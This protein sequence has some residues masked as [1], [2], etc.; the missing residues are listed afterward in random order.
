MAFCS[1]A[2]SRLTDTDAIPVNIHFLFRKTDDDHHWSGRR[3]LGMPQVVACLE[4]AR[5]RLNLATLRMTGRASIERRDK[6]E[7]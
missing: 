6:N 2:D 5:E 4:L 1:S 3:N 7:G